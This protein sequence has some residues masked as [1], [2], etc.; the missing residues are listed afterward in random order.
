MQ[1]WLLPWILTLSVTTYVEYVR[2]GEIS[3]FRHVQEQAYFSEPRSDQTSGHTNNQWVP[4]ERFGQYLSIETPWFTVLQIVWL[5]QLVKLGHF[6][7]N[8]KSAENSQFLTRLKSW[9]L[10]T[11]FQN[12]LIQRW[13]KIF[14]WNQSHMI[15]NKLNFHVVKAALWYLFPFRSYSKLEKWPTLGEKI[16]FFWEICLQYWRTPRFNPPQ[17]YIG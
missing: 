9:F 8:Q 13:I 4:N 14:S 17:A 12:T 5:L 7:K 16:L 2:T 6:S 10:E 11:F 1:S 15:P 3:G